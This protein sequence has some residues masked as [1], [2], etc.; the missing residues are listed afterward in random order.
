MELT[1][2][3]TVPLSVERTWAFL[4]DLQRVAPC[5][6]GAA[7]LGSEGDDYLGAVKIKVGPVTANYRGTARFVE[8]DETAR[9]AVIRAEGK[10]VG[11]QGNAAAT[12]TAHLSGEG[13]STTVRVDTDL[14][15]SGRVAQF[16]R[17]VI[18]DISNKLMGQFAQ[19]LEAAVAD[20]GSDN[21]EG[22]LNS[23]N[24]S[25]S[26]PAVSL[27]E[28]EPLDVMAGMGA[29]IAKRAAPLAGAVAS[30]VALLFVLLRRRAAP[31]RAGSPGPG[32]VVINLTLPAGLLPGV[33]ASTR[34]EVLH[35]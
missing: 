10:D 15:L 4:T 18:A 34:K 21:R 6:P 27:D 30:L 8:R 29:V 7:L 35:D 17:G 20:S 31:R 13:S 22:Y 1:N 32:H 19:R 23:V 9:R 2:T 24:G 3:F 14:A 33:V 11:G 25:A 28:V 5:L 12:I 26:A 16:G